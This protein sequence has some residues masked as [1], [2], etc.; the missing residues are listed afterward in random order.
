LQPQPFGVAFA[1]T[2]SPPDAQGK[3]TLD[4]SDLCSTEPGVPVPPP[5]FGAPGLM[6]DEG[7]EFELSAESID[8]LHRVA[9]SKELLGRIK[10]I[11]ERIR[12]NP[13]QKLYEPLVNY[14]TKYF[15]QH[16]VKLNKTVTVMFIKLIKLFVNMIG[17]KS[18]STA[19]KR[20]NLKMKG[21]ISVEILFKLQGLST[22]KLLLSITHILVKK[23]DCN[24]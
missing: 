21:G 10:K 12:T 5:T 8:T 6:H 16:F 24:K 22:V 1:G 18:W 3:V 19:A 14:Y 23:K 7:E 17:P 2:I 15:V 4:I 20:T 13:E 9:S 11:D